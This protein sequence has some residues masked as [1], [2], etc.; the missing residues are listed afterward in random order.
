MRPPDMA[1]EAESGESVR[2]RASAIVAM[3]AKGPCCLTFS[4]NENKAGVGLSGLFF[5]KESVDFVVSSVSFM[6]E[7]FSIESDSISSSSEGVALLY[8][9]K[10][11]GRFA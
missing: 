1:A 11:F 4:R 8:A 9:L 2:A 10:I 5:F 3:A 7:S 6:L